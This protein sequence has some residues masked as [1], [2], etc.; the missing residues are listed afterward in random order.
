MQGDKDERVLATA[1]VDEEHGQE[2][3]GQVKRMMV[4]D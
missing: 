3:P 4:R 1:R 2:T